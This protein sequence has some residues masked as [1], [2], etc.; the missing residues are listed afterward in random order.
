MA[1]PLLQ[2]SLVS[3]VGQAASFAIG[4][5]LLLAGIIVTVVS[6]PPAASSTA[7]PGRASFLWMVIGALAA[8]AVVYTMAARLLPVLFAGPLDVNRGD[9]LV[10]TEAGVRRALEGSTP[11]TLYHVPWEMTLSYGPMLWGPYV[12]PVIAHAD[13]RVLTMIC[14]GVVTVALTLAAVHAAANRLW[15]NAIGILVLSAGL[16]LHPYIS[17]FFPIGHTFVYW[18]L[19]L[20]FCGLLASGRWYAAAA[21]LGLLVCARS[22]MVSLV[23]VF[24]MAAYHQRRLNWRL[25]G[26]LALAAIG[27]FVP[28]VIADPRSVQFA[29]YGAYQ[30]T[31]KGFVWT[32]TSWVQQTFGVTGP[33]L[34]R[35]WQSYSEIVQIVSLVTV[36][37]LA[38]RPL[39][40]GNDPEPWLALSLAVFSMTTLWPVTYLYF[41][42]WI[43]LLGGIAVRSV[44]SLPRR[45]FILPAIAGLAF[46][47]SAGAVLSAGWV[48]HGTYALD[49][50]TA[51]SAPMTGGGF[52]TDQRTVDGDR[53][54]VWIEG[55]AARVRVPHA[56]FTSATIRID[57]KPFAETTPRQRLRVSVNGRVV[58]DTVL[59]SGWQTV[60]FLA[61]AS[62]WQY[63]FNVLTMEFTETRPEP[64]TDR[65]LSAGIDKIQVR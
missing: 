51:A 27:P 55:T 32:Q 64:G 26:V 22:T 25:M 50:G 47:V 48:L 17:T 29:M 3:A 31:I 39:A 35:G 58:G 56:G 13:V 44:P 40:R 18:P 41:D 37:A 43:I 60:S 52:G 42:V 16:S 59:N 61:P 20:I 10:V 7:Q 24:L 8:F 28:F 21:A 12:L 33:L 62:R 36:Y 4:T 23:P 54:F 57:L 34:T 2:P 5:A 9:M 49:V 63:G 45:R 6:W 1:A 30:K 65:L 15:M 19:L 46:V 11:Y 14:F 53:D 38:W